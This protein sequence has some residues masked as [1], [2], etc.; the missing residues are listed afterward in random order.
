M[1]SSV[2]AFEKLLGSLALSALGSYF[3]PKSGIQASK[4]LMSLDHA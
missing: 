2:Q 4:S 1:A 3:Y